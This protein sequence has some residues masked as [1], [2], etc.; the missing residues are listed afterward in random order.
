MLRPSAAPRWKMTTRR[1]FFA[2]TDSAAYAARVRN[3]GIAA[4]PITANPPFLMNTRLVIDIL[5]LLASGSWLP[6]SDASR[7]HTCLYETRFSVLRSRFS[8]IFFETRVIL[9][10]SLRSGWRLAAG[11]DRPACGG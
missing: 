2:P 5:Q 8:V 1:L 6:A 9:T 11:L 7:A 4:V 3:A 10:I